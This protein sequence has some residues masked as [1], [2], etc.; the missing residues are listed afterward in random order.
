[1]LAKPPFADAQTIRDFGSYLPVGLD[2]RP[3]DPA[4]HGQAAETW[5]ILSETPPP[6]SVAHPEFFGNHLFDTSIL[7]LE[8]APEQV[9]LTVDE[10]AASTFA[11]ALA[12]VL[13]VARPR[14]P[15]PV[16]LLLS[17][18]TCVRMVTHDDA[19]RL[20]EIDL[21]DALDDATLVNEWF[22]PRDDGLAWVA[23]VYQPAF[24]PPAAHL[25][26]ECRRATAVDRRRD[27]LAAAFGPA[28]VPLW[29]DALRELAK[30]DLAGPLWNVD[31]LIDFLRGRAS[32]QGL[33][34]R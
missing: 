29:E 4:E 21:A 24:G 6:P 33:S 12:H 30:G 26:V 20:D 34:P 11:N 16:D 17:E 23:E 13:K 7:H 10:D 27:A 31:E 28:V 2:G 19:G 22:L 15:W 25:L 9:R 8:I 14:G 5:R 3:Y 18:P 32:P 1:M